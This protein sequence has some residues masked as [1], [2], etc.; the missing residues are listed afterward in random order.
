M[1]QDVFAGLTWEQKKVNI[2]GKFLSSLRL[3]DDVILI[4]TDA[5]ELTIILSELKGVECVDTHTLEMVVFL[6][7]NNRL[8]KDNQTAKITRRVRLTWAAFTHPQNGHLHQ[9]E[10]E[11]LRRLH[12]DRHDLRAQDCN[13]NTNQ[14]SPSPSFVNGQ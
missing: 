10:V 7:H 8:D 6:D 4:S 12:I 2:D 3:P 5:E 1:L 14:C 11:S 9:L 13:P